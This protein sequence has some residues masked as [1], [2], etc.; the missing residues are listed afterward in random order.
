MCQKNT[1][2][3]IYHNRKDNGLGFFICQF[4][5]LIGRVWNKNKWVQSGFEEFLK[6]EMGLGQA[7]I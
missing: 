4:L 1:N 5:S 2:N 6:P 3:V 7:Y